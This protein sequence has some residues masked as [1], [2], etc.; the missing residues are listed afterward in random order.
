VLLDDATRLAERARAA[1]VDVI[2][3]VVAGV[4][5]VF[6][7]FAGGSLDEADQALDLAALFLIQQL[8]NVPTA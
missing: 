3:D 4:P 5:H 7:M 1:E 8:S 2:L 6:Q